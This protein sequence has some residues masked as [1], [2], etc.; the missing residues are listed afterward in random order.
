MDRRGREGTERSGARE[1]QS[2]LE[3]ENIQSVSV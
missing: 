3:K 1:L 2:R